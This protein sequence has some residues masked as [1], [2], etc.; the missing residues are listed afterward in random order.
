MAFALVIAYAA[1]RFFPDANVFVFTFL[2]LIGAAMPDIDNKRSKISQKAKMVSALI[3][4]LTKHRG[5]FH[6]VFIPLG[7]Y[8]LLDMILGGYYGMAL[9]LGYLSHLMIDAM[10]P[11]GVNFL[12]PITTLRLHGPIET[13]SFV[14]K[15]LLAGL[16]GILF[17]IGAPLIRTNP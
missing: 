9:A 10:T 14:E 17:F 11:L 2:I 12:H 6:S 7:I 16:V 8:F 3:N 15:I 1:Y 5:I 4:S 13:N